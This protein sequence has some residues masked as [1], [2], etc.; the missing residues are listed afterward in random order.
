MRPHALITTVKDV[1]LLSMSRNRAASLRSGEAG[2]IAVTALLVLAILALLGL[3]LF[4]LSVRDVQVSTN[5]GDATQSLYAAEAGIE[6]AYQQIKI[7]TITGTLNP[8]NWASPVSAPAIPV[9]G[10]GGSNYT[11]PTFTVAALF[12][13]CITTPTLPQCLQAVTMGVYQGLTASTQHYLITSEVT[14]P[15]QG[16]ARVTQAVQVGLIGLF[17]FAVFYQ[18]ALEIFPG[19]T[20]TLVGRVHSNAN[21]YVGNGTQINSFLTAAG[22]IFN[23][24][25]DNNGPCAVGTCN[26]PGG[27]LTA[28]ASI[29]NTA[30]SYVPLTYDHRSTSPAWASWALSTYGGLVRDS[31]L[32]AT[33]L[34]LPIDLAGGETPH[35][36]IEKGVG[37][38]S[39]TLQEQKLYWQADYRIIVNS[40]GSVTV[41]TGAF[42]SETTSSLDP[43][44]FLTTNT[45][46][47]DGREQKCV[48][49]AQINMGALRTA[50][51]WNF[52]KGILY[53]SSA[54]GDTGTCGTGTPNAART[55]VVRLT[56]A[57]QLPGPAAGFTVVSD[58]PVYIQGSY[59]TTNKVAAAVMG[60]AVT[61]LS[62]NW[63]PNNSDTK[64]FG[65]ASG[66]NRT[67]SATTINAALMSGNV[68][69]I[70]GSRYSGGLE[71]Y[72]RLL[73]AWSGVTLTYNG[74][75]VD[76]WPSLIATGAW[77]CCTY[78]NVPTRN[79]AFDVL[80]N[81][82]LPPGT[83]R[84]LVSQRLGWWHQE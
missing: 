25:F 82:T 56:N 11:F 19:A 9:P 48:Q 58:R 46:F 13:D 49:P 51:G 65:A 17:Q 76:L 18:Q 43:S 33:T 80:F 54:K 64:G 53:V 77:G 38:D 16:R 45:N 72:L 62:N 12:V 75:L 83:P 79:W 6:S 60:D 55:P 66:G 5:F 8:A 47:Y 39:T 10:G 1:R 74:S 14:T 15:N 69:T 44:S 21:A 26:G 30:G 63:G 84:V 24:R 7:N 59:N 52:T 27:G 37:G 23:Y 70:S 28:L 57:A 71:N 36:I 68:P 73:E 4:D 81:A 32:Q 31:A 34:N 61:V 40:N 50:P 78:Y 22:N 42:G 2:S 41:K 67:A 29:K 35:Q 3:S 20:M